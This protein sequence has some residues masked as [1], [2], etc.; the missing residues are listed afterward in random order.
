MCLDVEGDHAEGRRPTASRCHEDVHA[1]PAPGPG[2]EYDMSELE[3]LLEALAHLL[4]R[5]A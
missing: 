2:N 4:R 1:E 5:I 3:F